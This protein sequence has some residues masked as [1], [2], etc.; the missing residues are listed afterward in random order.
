MIEGGKSIFNSEFKI[1]NYSLLTTLYSQTKK[2]SEECFFLL[3]NCICSAVVV[4]WF[5]LAR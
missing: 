4:L 1:S 2:H 5:A 3:N